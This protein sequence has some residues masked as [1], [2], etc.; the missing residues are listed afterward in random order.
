M[1]IVEI[2]FK[3]EDIATALANA[4]IADG[5]AVTADGKAVTADGKA[6]TADGKA[7]TA[8]GKAVAAQADADSAQADATQA[9]LSVATV[10]ADAVKSQP[11]VGEYKVTGVKRNATG[12]VV[13][14]YNDVPHASI[15]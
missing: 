13:I 9:L 7:V 11:A 3:P 15:S 6:V 10:E 1:A 14:L 5:K 2:T 12:G 8:D 4:A